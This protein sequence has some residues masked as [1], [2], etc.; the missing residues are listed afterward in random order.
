MISTTQKRMKIFILTVGTAAT[1]FSVIFPGWA[2]HK[3]KRDHDDAPVQI[4]IA[5]IALVV[6]SVANPFQGTMEPARVLVRF[7][8]ATPDA[9]KIIGL[10]H[11]HAGQQAQIMYRIGRSGR[12]YVDSVE[13]LSHRSTDTLQP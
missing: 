12:L 6:P 10:D 11:L 1:L 8:G 7:H 13:P 5:P 2:R 9:K 4:G 3:Y